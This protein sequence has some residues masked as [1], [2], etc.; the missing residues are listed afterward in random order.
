MKRD[1]LMND[2][3]RYGGKNSKGYVLPPERAINID[4]KNDFMLA[5][6]I[7]SEL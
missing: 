3:M 7:M 5:E 2:G 1:Y 4:T 6:I